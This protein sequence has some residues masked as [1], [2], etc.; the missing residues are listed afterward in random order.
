MNDDGLLFIM[1]HIV[2]LLHAH[3][4]GQSKLFLLYTCDQVEQ[5][6]K[7]EETL[8]WVDIHIPL[9]CSVR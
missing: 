3:V 8:F 1:N 9:L 4:E 5:E 7:G 6:G 2:D